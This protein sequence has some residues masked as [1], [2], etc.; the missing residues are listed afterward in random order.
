MMSQNP[1]KLDTAYGNHMLSI[2][3]FLQTIW[4]EGMQ[5]AVKAHY[6]IPLF[7]RTGFSDNLIKGASADGIEVISQLLQWDPKKRPTAAQVS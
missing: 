4:S 2:L 1:S 5:L 7:V 6:K 3:F